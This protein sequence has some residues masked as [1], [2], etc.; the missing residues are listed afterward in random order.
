MNGDRPQHPAWPEGF[1]FPGLPQPSP[2]DRVHGGPPPRDK[3]RSRALGQDIVGNMMGQICAWD[4]QQSPDA[5]TLVA[6]LK[7]YDFAEAAV[8]NIDIS[9]PLIDPFA[10]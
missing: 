3:R 5:E 9:N 4:D 8:P 1:P 6:F 10:G 7:A 2:D